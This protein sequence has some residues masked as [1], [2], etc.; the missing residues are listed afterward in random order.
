MLV[1][2]NATDTNFNGKIDHVTAVFS[3]TL[4]AYTAGITPWTLT[5]VP[6]GGTLASVTVATTTATLNHHR[7]RRRGRHHRRLV[8][9]RTGHQRP[10]GP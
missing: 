2:L 4:S 6:S 1:T 7:R 3:E 9:R 8:H 5:A 10:R